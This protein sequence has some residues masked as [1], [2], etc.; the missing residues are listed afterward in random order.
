MA[1]DL[2]LHKSGLVLT[3]DPHQ[4][5]V[6]VLMNNSRYDIIGALME[7]S[8]NS[9]DQGCYED[10]VHKL[11]TCLQLEDRV[12]NR[13][14]IFNKLGQCFLDLGW[15]EEALKAYAQF[16]EVYP[17]DK[18]GR[19]FL[20]HAYACS[21]WYD[22]AIVELK[23]VLASDP[24]DIL[25]R[26]GLALCYRDTGRLE[27]ALREVRRANEY[28]MNYGRPDEREIVASSLAHIEYEVENGVEY[29]PNDPYF[30]SRDWQKSGKDPN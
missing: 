26:H 17:S 20:A 15:H 12:K 29:D 25:A 24:S 3:E 11:Q 7:E 4:S 1:K 18:D 6:Q 2:K 9:I 23:S 14:T 19:F 8:C 10:A 21:G 13:A 27:E 28:A 22:E 5:S 16:L 30:R